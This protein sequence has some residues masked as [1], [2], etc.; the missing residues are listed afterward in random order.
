[1]DETIARLQSFSEEIQREEPA[2]KKRREKAEA[3]RLRREVLRS[4]FLEELRSSGRCAKC[5]DPLSF[6][7]KLFKRHKHKKCNPYRV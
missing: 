2:E 1:M 4:E 7:D 6:L 3:E 5:G